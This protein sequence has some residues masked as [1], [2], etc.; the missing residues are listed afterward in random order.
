MKKMS[1]R[2]IH[3]INIALSITAVGIIVFYDI[4]GG[5]CSYLKGSIFG[6]DLKYAGIIYMIALISLNILK[7]DLPILLF[8]SMALGV[9]AYLIGF[10]ISYWTFC[11]FCFAFGII[12]ISQFI[13]NFNWS[14][15]WYM[16][17]CIIIGLLFCVFF[18][19]GSI[20]PTYDIGSLNS[21]FGCFSGVCRM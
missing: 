7:W 8:V 18:F 13:F 9:E 20:I 21:P 19:K 15:R 6:I 12:V 17:S 11:P 3:I 2:T 1:N 16:I 5:T 4:C 10:Q 14:S